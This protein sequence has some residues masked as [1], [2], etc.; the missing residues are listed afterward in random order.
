MLRERS[1]VE[2][3]IDGYEK[4]A[5]GMDDLTVYLE[6]ALNKLDNGSRVRPA[7]APAYA[8]WRLAELNASLG[9]TAET[10]AAADKLITKFPDARYVSAALL[11]VQI[12]QQPCLTPLPFRQPYFCQRLSRLLYPQTQHQTQ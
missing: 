6:G 5:A 1:A 8:A 4:L 2:A 11:L 12:V 10:L 7:W 9:K 3:S